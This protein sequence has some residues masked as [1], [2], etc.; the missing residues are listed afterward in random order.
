MLRKFGFRIGKAR[1]VAL[2]FTMGLT[3]FLVLA[4]SV[5]LDQTGRAGAF[6][7]LPLF[8]PGAHASEYDLKNMMAEGY[9]PH[10][11]HTSSVHVNSQ[12]HA[13]KLGLGMA[14][15]RTDQG[16]AIFLLGLIFSA[17][18][19]FNMAF[20]RHLRA[21]YTPSKHQRTLR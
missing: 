12:K 11:Q 2:D 6:Q 13:S 16:T 20:Y 18:F 19:A 15:A 10:L 14:F 17:V 1:R 3:V 21:V 8:V 4:F 9:G 7:N 5:T